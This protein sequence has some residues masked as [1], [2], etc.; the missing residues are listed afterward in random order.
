MKK[1]QKLLLRMFVDF[2]CEECKKHEEEVGILEPHRIRPGS[3]GGDYH[4]RNVKMVCHN[5]HDIY[6]SALRK[7]I[8]VQK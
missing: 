3:D 8:G 6:S 1:T 7:T 2:T 4:F 5:C